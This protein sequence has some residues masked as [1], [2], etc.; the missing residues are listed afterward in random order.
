[1]KPF[2]LRI[3]AFCWA[4]AFVAT[5]ALAERPG[6]PDLVAAAYETLHLV[7]DLADVTVRPW[8]RR[9][10]VREGDLARY[11]LRM[12][13]GWEKI[14]A[15]APER[16]VVVLVHG[17]NSTPIRNAGIMAAVRRAGYAA[18]VFAYPNDWSLEKSAAWLSRDLAALAADHPEAPIALATHSMGGLV[19]RACVENP[20][21]DPG[22]VTRLVMIAPP[23]HGSLVARFSVGADLWEHWLARRDG[24]FKQRWRDSVIDG[25]DEAGDDLTPGSRFLT[26]LNARPRNPRIR[27]AIFL[28]T[29]APV[30]KSES[31]LL[32]WTLRKS[33]RRVEWLGAH[34]DEIDAALAEFDEVID[35]KGDGVV[36]VE[37]GRL[38]GV[39]DVVLLPFDHLSCTDEPGNDAV[40]QVQAELLAR[41]R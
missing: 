13:E 35:G 23:T 24:G 1:V 11:G 31:K 30:T 34:A 12:D 20:D 14:A 21:L 36:A 40:R 41:L 39:D 15:A 25:L 3:T 6:E 9:G 16:S 33:L 8:L 38:D 19:A 29:D 27:Y 5:P 28:G 7:G 18:G 32:R 26:Q 10:V 22:N 2:F 37:R 17:Y 4:A